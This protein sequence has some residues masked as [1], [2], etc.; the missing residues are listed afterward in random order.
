[1]PTLE[2]GI[3]D[4]EEAP[5]WTFECEGFTPVVKQWMGEAAAHFAALLAE[6]TAG[7]VTRVHC[8]YT[9]LDGGS[10]TYAVY[11]DNGRQQVIVIWRG[12]MT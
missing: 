9:A 8:A 3:H 7:T 2:P 1:M 6:Q 10:G 4:P 11:F 5:Y 12:D